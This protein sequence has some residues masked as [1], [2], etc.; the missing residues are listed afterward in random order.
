MTYQQLQNYIKSLQVAKKNI[1]TETNGI[2]VAAAVAVPVN[3]NDNDE[4][5]IAT[6]II[7]VSNS[8]TASSSAAASSVVLTDQEHNLNLFQKRNEL[9]G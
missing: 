5:P 8:T 2:L 4:I 7:S 6:E 9:L 1:N 3:N